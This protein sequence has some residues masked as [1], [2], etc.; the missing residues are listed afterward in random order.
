[1]NVLQLTT[2]FLHSLDQISNRFASVGEALGL[3]LAS[4]ADKAGGAVTTIS[5]VVGTAFSAGVDAS[6]N[7]LAS[8]GGMFVNTGM[9]IG[10]VTFPGFAALGAASA[11]AGFASLGITAGAFFASLASQTSSGII[12]VSS[13]VATKIQALIPPQVSLTSITPE[14]NSEAV[15]PSEAFSSATVDNNEDKTSADQQV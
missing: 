7:V 3:T 6:S 10:S 4:V 14:I 8:T 5:D 11:V 15:A 1:M 12:D 13:S 9:T 2:S